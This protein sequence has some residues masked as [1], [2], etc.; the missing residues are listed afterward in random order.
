ITSTARSN[1]YQGP[2]SVRRMKNPSGSASIKTSTG[3][4]APPRVSHSPMAR[5]L[6][7]G[8]GV[9]EHELAAGT[10]PQPPWHAPIQSAGPLRAG[11]DDP[12]RGHALAGRAASGD[13]LEAR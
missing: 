7:A 1:P 5:S 10:A 9:I 8:S 6:P 3:I 12:P 4:R 2:F 11:P 13:L